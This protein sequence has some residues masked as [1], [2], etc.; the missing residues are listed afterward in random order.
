MI[1]ILIKWFEVDFPDIELMGIAT[2]SKDNDFYG[3]WVVTIQD[4]TILHKTSSVFDKRF[5]PP[6][7]ERK[8]VMEEVENLAKAYY[9][10]IHK[11]ETVHKWM[12]DDG[13]FRKYI[14]GK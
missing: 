3:Q 12:E 1:R 10:G 6:I 14:G 7:C 11:L 2:V 13:G 8:D 9:A 4:G 5:L